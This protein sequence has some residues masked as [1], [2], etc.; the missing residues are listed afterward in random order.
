MAK[1][2]NCVTQSEQEIQLLSFVLIGFRVP[3]MNF[4]FA[5]RVLCDVTSRST[6][7]QDFLQLILT[8]HPY[9]YA[10]LNKKQYRE[11]Y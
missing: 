9:I 1:S 2:N 7:D 8:A 5:L 6:R 10:N 3:M 4:I 11:I